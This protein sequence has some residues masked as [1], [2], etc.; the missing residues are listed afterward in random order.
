MMQE[1][2]SYS[3]IDRVNREGLELGLAA[4]R[5][6]FRE[7]K[8]KEEAAEALQEIAN[9][10]GVIDD[11]VKVRIDHEVWSRFKKQQQTM[12]ERESIITHFLYNK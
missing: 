12:H 7:G 4:N 1:I 5:I 9:Q 8:S 2:L 10:I 6:E 11:L 3:R